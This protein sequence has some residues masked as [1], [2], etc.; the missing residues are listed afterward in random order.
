MH[1]GP[2]GEGIGRAVAAVVLLLAV[3]AVT[4]LVLIAVVAAVFVLVTIVAAVFVVVTVVVSPV[5]VAAAAPGAVVAPVVAP[6]SLLEL[7]PRWRPWWPA[8][9]SLS[10]SI[11]VEAVTRPETLVPLARSMVSTPFAK[12]LTTPARSAPSLM[13]SSSLSQSR[14]S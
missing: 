13:P 3:V 9:S 7:R 11:S 5:L 1:R 12:D 14:G 6:S 4:V 10:H 2:C 8:S